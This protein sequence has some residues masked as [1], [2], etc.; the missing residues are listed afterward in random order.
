MV[1][2]IKQDFGKTWAP[3]FYDPK[4]VRSFFFYVFYFL[5]HFLLFIRYNF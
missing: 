5:L 3:I 1:K 2:K 4:I